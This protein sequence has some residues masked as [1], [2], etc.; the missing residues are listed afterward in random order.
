ML[1]SFAR[2][3]NISPKEQD[4]DSLNFFVFR[5]LF[6]L[7]LLRDDM[8]EQCHHA[9][10]VRLDHLFPSSLVHLPRVPHKHVLHHAAVLSLPGLLVLL[11]Q[12]LK[13]AELP[14]PF[15]VLQ[16][17]FPHTSVK[18]RPNTPVGVVLLRHALEPLAHR[19][20]LLQLQRKLELLG[21]SSE[22]RNR[23]GFRIRFVLMPVRSGQFILELKYPGIKHAPLILHIDPSKSH[24]CKFH[25]TT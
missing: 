2:S 1:K 9:V 14:F 5:Q 13:V 6:Y 15:Q 25:P 24:P 20:L 3:P 7:L 8:H 21:S 23:Q 10:G 18:H 16:N 22:H 4:W 19:M 12:N 17:P 11:V